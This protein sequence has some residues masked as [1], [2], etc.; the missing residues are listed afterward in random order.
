MA[1]THT[2]SSGP[3]AEMVV[4]LRSET[5]Q[6]LVNH[7]ADG[8]DIAFDINFFKALEGISPEEAAQLT[9]EVAAQAA[10]ASPPA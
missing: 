4:F 6:F 10:S 5:D 2:P 1:S 8:T 3:G 7:M 9:E